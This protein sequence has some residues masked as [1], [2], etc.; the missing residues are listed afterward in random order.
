M[1]NVCGTLTAES[2]F[3]NEA[4]NT[5]FARVSVIWIHLL[6]LESSPQEHLEND[7]TYV[8][9]V[10][11]ELTTDRVL[12]MEWIDG[13]KVLPLLSCDVFLHCVLRS[14]TPRLLRGR[15]SR[16]PMRSTS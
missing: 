3:L 16:L 2:S 15:A 4:K 11:D 13:V 6:W 14:P 9:A 7:D 12:T 5:K 8:P 10:Y 1:D